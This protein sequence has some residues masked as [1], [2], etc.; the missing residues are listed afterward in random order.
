MDYE[1]ESHTCGWELIQQI[2]PDLWPE[3]EA[4]IV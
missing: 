1:I 4:K 3:I 2:H